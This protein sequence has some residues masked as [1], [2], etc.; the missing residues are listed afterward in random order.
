MSLLVPYTYTS[1]DRKQ[2][3]SLTHSTPNRDPIGWVG[4][5]WVP[6][7]WVLLGKK[8]V[9]GSLAFLSTDEDGGG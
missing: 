2:P 3:Y 9:T 1:V 4:A 6:S 7:D 5:C 8:K